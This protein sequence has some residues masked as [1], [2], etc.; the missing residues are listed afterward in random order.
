MVH[1]LHNLRTGPEIVAQ[2]HPSSLPWPGCLGGTIGIVLFQENTW[3]CLAELV[4]GL[5]DVTHQEAILSFPGQ[6]VKNGILNAV[7]ILIFIHQ[8]LPESPPHFHRHRRGCGPVLAQQQVQRPVLQVAEIQNVPLLFQ[9]FI[10]HRKLPHQLH[11]PPLGLGA[12]VKIRRNF[13]RAAAKDLCPVGKLCFE[14]LPDGLNQSLCVLVYVLFGEAQSAKVN[15]DAQDHLVPVLA[16]PQ[17]FCPGEQRLQIGTDLL[18]ILGRLNTALQSG[19]VAVQPGEKA[20]HQ[21]SAP[22]RLAHILWQAFG[23]AQAVI[24]PFFRVFVAAGAG[25]DLFDDLSQLLVAA[26]QVLALRKG[27]EIRVLQQG[28]V[29]PLQHLLH[30]LLPQLPGPILICDTKIRFQVQPIGILPQKVP[31]ETMDRR[32]LGQIQSLELLLQAAVF[33]LLGNTL[34]ELLGDLRP[35]LPGS[36]P[37]ISNNQEFIQL[38]RI[39]RVCQIGHEPIHQDLCLAGT[40]GSADQQPPAPV[41]HRKGLGRGQLLSHGAFPP[42]LPFPR[43]A[44]H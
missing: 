26:A 6:A 17:I 18:H 19:D 28:I 22:H 24:Q 25:I 7:G 4:D 11:Q 16:L 39:H 9:L 13:R 21:R 15:P 12:E 8:H 31:A 32:N 38:G 34:R 44:L 3:V 23:M 42:F 30:G 27:A 37:G 20:V 41:L 2:Q 33:R 1:R 29:G 43:S 14:P 10:L 40:G 36:G 35:Q 5:L